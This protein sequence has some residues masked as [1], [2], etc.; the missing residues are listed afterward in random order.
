[1]NLDFLKKLCAAHG[2]AGFEDEARDVILEY[3]KP[4]ID[5]HRVDAM[6]NL[7]AHKKGPGPKMMLA[8]HVDQI[9]FMVTFISKEGFLHISPIGGLSPIL[10]WVRAL[11]FPMGRSAWLIRSGW[12]ISG[13]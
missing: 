8:G 13:I 4:Y 10:S 7:I 1:M 5:D 6:G 9:G 11:F 2:V 12:I 3:I